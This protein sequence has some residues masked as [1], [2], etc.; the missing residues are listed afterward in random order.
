MSDNGVG[1]E[2]QIAMGFSLLDEER[3]PQ[4]IG[5]KYVITKLRHTFGDDC[6]FSIRSVPG[7]GTKVILDM[8]AVWSRG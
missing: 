7:Q 8:P 2:D 5:I 6:S 1:F 4:G 3:K